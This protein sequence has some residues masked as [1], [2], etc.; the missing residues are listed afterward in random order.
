M[1]I[2]RVTGVLCWVRQRFDK[3][4]TDKIVRR[5]DWLLACPHVLVVVSG[6]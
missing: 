4:G 2:G 6:V 3:G 5:A 1:V